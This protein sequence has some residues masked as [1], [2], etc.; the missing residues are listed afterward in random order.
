MDLPFSKGGADARCSKWRAACTHALLGWLRGHAAANSI[1]PTQNPHQTEEF[2][3]CVLGHSSLAERGVS[4][5]T[6]LNVLYFG[7]DSN[8]IF[9]FRQH[10]LCVSLHNEHI[11]SMIKIYSLYTVFD[12]VDLD[13]RNA[14]LIYLRRTLRNEGYR[15]PAT[16]R[17]GTNG[18]RACFLV[19]WR[20]PFNSHLVHGETKDQSAVSI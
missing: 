15:L 2:S 10:I 18:V 12:A 17:N 7:F 16:K 6:K 19:Q 8:F 14:F 13:G 1:C 20:R 9:S 11:K 5:S 3:K 4:T